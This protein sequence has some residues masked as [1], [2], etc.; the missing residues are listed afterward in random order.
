VIVAA[1]CI[2]ALSTAYVLYLL[3]EWFGRLILFFATR[4][5][6]RVRVIGRDNFPDKTGA[7]LVCNHMSFVDVALLVSATDRPIRFIEYRGIYDHPIVKPF[8]KMV[9]AIPISSEQ[10]PREMLQ[11]LRSATDALRNNEIV[12]IFAGG[13]ITRTGQLLPFRRGL[14]RIMKGVA[15]PIIPVNLDGVWG[16]TF[17]F[18]RGRLLWKMPR[19]IPYRVTVSF[20]Q[21]MPAT[22]SAIEVR[23]AVQELNTAAFEMRKP[24]MKTLDR[25]FVC[26]ARQRPFQFFMADGKTERVTL[27]S[28]LS[29]AVY[30]ARRLRRQ[31]GDKPMV[32]LLVPPSV[33]G[34]M[35]NYA[36]MLIGRVPVNLNYTSS[37]Q[38]IAS[39]ASQCGL[40]TVVT[41]KAFLERFPNMSIPGRTVLLEDALGSPRLS[42]KLAVL[43]VA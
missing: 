3:P 24:H 36:L 14:E 10:H 27:G 16:S 5:V 43:S 39:C 17:S 15:V 30:I 34:A 13:Q 19:R 41:S 9:K 20:G 42:E 37:N 4:T 31:V 35:T 18:E 40:D 1:S 38:T 26:A 11:S 29:K 12:C 28:A 21:P 6:Y 7:L 8:A 25:A 2:T 32:G 33:G 23:A 22:S